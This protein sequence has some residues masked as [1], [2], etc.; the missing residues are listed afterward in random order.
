MTALM[1][2]DFVRLLF[3]ALLAWWLFGEKLDSW[4][5]AGAALIIA[6]SMLAAREGNRMVKQDMERAQRVDAKE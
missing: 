6:G 4:T 5:V 3:T 1:P 2:F